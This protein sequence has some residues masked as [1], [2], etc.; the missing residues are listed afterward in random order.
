MKTQVDLLRDENLELQQRL[1]ELQKKYNILQADNR[2]Q[3]GREFGSSYAERLVKL[4]YELHGSD[5]YRFVFL[6]Y[7]LNK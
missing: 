7:T 6:I 5:L 1:A 4:V 2:L 3:N